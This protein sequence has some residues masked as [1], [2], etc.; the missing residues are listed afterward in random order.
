MPQSAYVVRFNGKYNLTKAVV[1]LT[2]YYFTVNLHWSGLTQAEIWERSNVSFSYLCSRL[3]E[4]A[5]SRRAW[6][7]Q[8]LGRRATTRNARP[9]FVY[10][11]SAY[12]K[13]WVISKMPVDLRQSLVDNYMPR[14]KMLKERG[15]TIPMRL[16]VPQKFEPLA[17]K[18][19]HAHKNIK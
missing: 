10:H 16:A 19:Y 8:Y 7:H 5:N 17:G 6:R 9:V 4:F 13:D 18:F 1:L 14:W 15:S 2:I 12:G 11:L 3:P